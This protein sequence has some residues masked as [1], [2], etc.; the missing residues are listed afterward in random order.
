[1]E[2]RSY[3]ASVLLL[4][5]AAIWGTA[6][7]AQ[8]A[9]M[10]SVGPFTF[11]AA[12]FLLGALIVLPLAAGRLRRGATGSLTRRGT[13]GAIALCGGILFGGS[14]MQQI[15]LVTSSAGK[16]GFITGLYIVIVPLLETALGRRP[17]AGEIAGAAVSTA[18]LFL[19]TVTGDFS[20][21]A[22]DLWV[23]GGAFLWAAH[24]VVVARVSPRIDTFVLAAGQFLVTA[25]LSLGAALA[26]EGVAPSG[27]RAAA[28]PILY[29]GVLSVGIAYTLQVSAQKRVPPS[30]AAIL[31]SLESP[32]AAAAGWI[33]LGETLSARALAGAA[34]MLAGT[35][36]AQLGPKRVSRAAP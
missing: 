9:G 12:R 6:F 24:V 31:M 13:V 26:V 17:A 10:E 27:L 19:L 15:G 29:G 7:V 18:G 16:A 21:A 8:R 20:V 4:V 28:A 2:R 5:T 32:F 34:L 30:L 23:I 1:M 22:G 36:V 35:T 11:N 33:A 25:F 3:G 14:A